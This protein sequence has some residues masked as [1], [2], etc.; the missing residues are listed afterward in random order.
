MFQKYKF[1]FIFLSILLFGLLI[2]ILPLQDNNFFF[3]I[4]QGSDAMYAREIFFRHQTL[5]VGPET[6]I[7]GVFAGPL[8]YYFISLGYFLFQGNPVGAVYIQILLNLILTSLIIIVI[9]KKQS[10]KLALIV[11]LLLQIFWP[12]YQTSQYSFNPFPHVFFTFTLLALLTS[13]WSGKAKYYL[14]GAIPIGLGFHFEIAYAIALLLFYSVIGI[15]GIIKKLIPISYVLLGIGIVIFLQYLQIIYEIQNNFSQ[16]HFFLNYFYTTDNELKSTQ[17]IPMAKIFFTMIGQSV[18]IQNWIIGFLIYITL[19]IFFFKKK[20]S[21]L[22][23][24]LKRFIILSFSLVLISWFWFSI[25]KGWRQWH[26][27]ALPPLLFVCTLFLIYGLSRKLKYFF[28]FLIISSQ[29]LFFLNQYDHYLKPNSDPAI[30]YNQIKTLDWI[31]HQASNKGFYVYTYEP[32]VYDTTS[33]Y[34]FWWYGNY[35]YGY[36]PCEYSSYPDSPDLFVPGWKHYQK[37]KRKCEET[38][39]L[40]MYPDRNQSIDQIWYEGVSKGTNL[41]AETSIGKIKIEKRTTR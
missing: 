15:V 19:L 13:I 23:T 41:E 1:L 12:F 3:T 30:L 8:Y 4:D 11:G 20:T 36:V 2:R 16:L 9:K 7:K 40:L 14:L 39:F 17:F 22:N 38:R 21:F 31:Y 24:W 5:L 18:F 32:S 33:Q 37:A 6:N 10:S 34:L 25:T 29:T 28:F 27:I 35:R 26:T